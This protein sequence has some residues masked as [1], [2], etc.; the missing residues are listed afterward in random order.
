MRRSVDRVL[1][2]SS[3]LVVLSGY[4]AIATAPRFSGFLVIIPILLTGLM[5]LGEW[6]DGRFRGYRRLSRAAVILYL[7]FIPMSLL[8]WDLLISVISLII[9]VQAFTLLHRKRSR[10]YYN[11]Y[12]MSFFLVL[13]ACVQA[14]EASIGFVLFL[15]LVSATVAFMTLQFH[16]ELEGVKEGILPD[17]VPLHVHEVVSPDRDN[18]VFDIGLIVAMGVVSVAALSLTIVLFFAMPRVEAGLLGRADTSLFSPG[19]SSEVSLSEG[20]FL[21]RDE[22][23]IMRVEFPEEPGGR[24]RGP[25][26]WRCTSLVTYADQKWTP[27]PLTPDPDW[28]QFTLL[29]PSIL[30]PSFRRAY[31]VARQPFAEGRRVR[32]SVFID[33]IPQDGLPALPVIQRMVG[34]GASHGVS[35]VWS[36]SG[37]FSARTRRMGQPW[38]QYNV[39]SEIE[40]ASP[41]ELRAAPDTYADVLAAEDYALLTAHDLEPQTVELARRITRDRGSPYDK[42]QAMVSYFHTRRF[43]YSRTIPPL[44]Q[45]HPVDRFVREVRIGHC[46]L[47]A[48]AMA[49]MLRSQGIPARVATGYRGGEWSEADRAYTV[50]ADMA[51]MWVEVLFIGIGWVAFDPSPADQFA[52]DTGV[53]RLTRLISRYVLRSKI[54]WYRGVVGYSGGLQLATIREI[55]LGLVNLGTGLLPPSYERTVAYRGRPW[56]VGVSAG[57][58]ILAVLLRVVAKWT[59]M[60]G[61]RQRLTRD[62]I[63]AIRLYRRLC[64][65]LHRH[66]VSCTGK[67]AEEIHDEAGSAGVL[68]QTVLS[69]VLAK[70]NGARFGGRVLSVKEYRTLKRRI[71]LSRSHL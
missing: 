33:E 32:Q 14:P 41:D 55:G 58:V 37:D 28:P 64:G 7:V 57:A 10:D 23:A 53:S 56:I 71:R 65:V 20:G 47:F 27:A 46:E 31:E 39:W 5:P 43:E 15:F 13:A 45:V 19:I 26:F 29:A 21:A 48:T 2:I 59:P 17:I 50:R 3:F 16:N 38:L 61:S 69:E 60:R 11:L 49:L 54:M 1:R 4:L 66:G 35:L 25:L 63:R 51:H 42:A 8:I 52:D 40:T 67:T 24:Y 9:F 18:R 12:L 44:P 6:L 30:A 68:D 70:Y 36:D 22:R 34:A 62:Q